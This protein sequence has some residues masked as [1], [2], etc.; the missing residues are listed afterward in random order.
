MKRLLSIS[1]LAPLAAAALLAGCTV[2]V[3]GSYPG[4]YPDRYPDRDPDRAYGYDDRADELRGTVA[5]VNTRDQLI[6]IDR[7]GD[8][9]RNDLRNEDAEDTA[10]FSYTESTVVRYQGQTFRPQDL[11]RGDRIQASVDRN[12]NRL[13][14]QDIEVLYDVSRGTGSPGY[15]P[16]RDGP[17]SG[18]SRGDDPGRYDPRDDGSR[19][20][21][22]ATDLR[23]TV[24]SID[25]R[26]RTLEIERSGYGSRGFS[27][28]TRPGPS[29]DLIVVRYD[30]GTTV[31]FQGRTYSPEN[32]ERGDEVR[33]QAARDRDGRLLAQEI[34][35]VGEDQP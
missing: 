30:A 20:D 28:G 35:V 15:D 33:I 7:E 10:V 1:F 18:D 12:G 26:S 22:L 21:D 6:Y 16:R 29:G 32:I 8:E 3:G 34:V 19:D 14:A 27:S 11:E 17:R 31:R 24:R 25:L 23:G 4:R 13:I 5:S 2:G 9:Y